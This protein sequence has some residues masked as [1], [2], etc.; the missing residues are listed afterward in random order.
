MKCDK[1]SKYYL[2]NC[3]DVEKYIKD[4]IDIFSNGILQVDEIGDGNINYVYR[5]MDIVSGK[6]VIVKQAAKEARISENMKLDIFR[7]KREAQ[8]LKIYNE[9]APGFVPKVYKYDEVMSVIVMEDIKDVLVAR[10]G[11][12]ELNI[13]PNFV[14]SVSTFL[15]RTLFFTSDLYLNHKLKKKYLKKF[16]NID[17]CDLTENL[18]FTEPYNNINNQNIVTEANVDFIEKNIYKNDIL[19]S[20]VAELKFKFMTNSQALLHGDLHTGA[21]FVNKK[22]IVV[23]DPEFVFYGPIGYDVGNLVANLCMNLCRVHFLV[24]EVEEAVEKFYAWLFNS[25]GEIIDSFMDKF[26]SLYEKNVTDVMAKNIGFKEKYFNDILSDTAGYAGTEC[27][28]RVVGIAKVPEITEIKDEKLRA[29]VEKKI[30]Q[31][32]IDMIINRNKYKTGAD[33]RSRLKNLL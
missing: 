17:L 27:I 6:S 26:N 28:R 7:G 3:N 32:G 19:H 4:K 22:D 33:Y 16:I 18:V 2:M 20:E 11:L 9:I 5:V 23:F 13:Y 1:F 10:K 12:M 30:L 25:I 8:L 15:S 31:I 14:E 29:E 24:K 21:I